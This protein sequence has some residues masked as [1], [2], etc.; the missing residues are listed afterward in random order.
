MIQCLDGVD[1]GLSQEIGNAYG[2]LQCKGAYCYRE[3]RGP[4]H[5]GECRAE[6]G[7]IMQE[8]AEDDFL[9]SAPKAPAALQQQSSD[10]Q[11]Q[12]RGYHTGSRSQAERMNIKVAHTV[13][14]KSPCTFT[15]ALHLPNNLSE[16]WS[17]LPLKA[18][19]F[20]LRSNLCHQDGNSQKQYD[21]CLGS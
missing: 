10:R 4:G 2:K 16:R 12:E 11:G 13:L 17:P 21:S 15:V 20:L 3:R 18:D 19:L 8:Q 14:Q 6:Q 7:K 1:K 5:G 9:H